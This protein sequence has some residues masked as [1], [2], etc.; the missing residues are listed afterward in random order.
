MKA[1]K[2]KILLSASIFLTFASPASALSPLL[3]QFVNVGQGDCE[4]IKTPNGQTILVDAGPADSFPAVEQALRANH[5]QTI[6]LF[7]ITHPHADHYG[8]SK[9]LSDFRV[10]EIWDSGAPSASRNFLRLLQTAKKQK[11]RYW[12]PSPGTTRMI[13]GCRI[14]VVAPTRPLLKDTRS[15]VNNSS[16]AFRLSY[17]KNSF[18]FP[19]DAELEA[20]E[21]M[22]AHYPDKLRSDVLKVAHHGSRN[23]TNSGVLVHVRPKVAVIG[24]GADNS[25]GHPTPIV[26]RLL[27]KLGAKVYRTDLDGT[28][29]ASSDGEKITWSTSN[30]DISEVPKISKTSRTS[31]TTDPSLLPDRFDGVLSTNEPAPPSS[32]KIEVIGRKSTGPVSINGATLME[33]DSIKGMTK[34]QAEAIIRSRPF[35]NL[36]DLL[37]VP[38]MTKAK[39]KRLKS[40]L[41]L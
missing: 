19:G 4:L 21:K 38:G 25:Y 9:L 23:A 10:K 16:I 8:D 32:G 29:T 39:L 12:Q 11:A 26:L 37:R 28:V 22:F 3:V 5:V 2:I 1:K 36:E 18:F 14:E 17:G 27:D 31:E 40:K 6:D 7:V 41:T 34:K 15:D 24:V 13:D 30:A 20:W 35:G 33:L